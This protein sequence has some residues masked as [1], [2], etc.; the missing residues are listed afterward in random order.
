M[1]RCCKRIGCALLTLLL[2]LSLSGMALA[3]AEPGEYT[4]ATDGGGSRK[5]VY[6]TASLKVSDDGS[7][8]LELLV[9][10]SMSGIKYQGTE[11]EPGE[12]VVKGED[13]YYPY[14]LIL[15]ERTD[16]VTLTA[17]VAAMGRDVELTVGLSGWDTVPGLEAAEEPG[18]AAG[19]EPGVDA[20]SH[21]IA[22]ANA[23]TS[24]YGATTVYPEASLTVAE[25]GS[26]AITVWLKDSIA[27]IRT[28]EGEAVPA[29]EGKTLSMNGE[30]GTYIPYTFAIDMRQAVL[31]LMDDVP[32]MSMVE[33][34]NYGKDMTTTINIDW[35]S[36]TDLEIAALEDGEYTLPVAF[37]TPS[38]MLQLEP[39]AE[40]AVS[41]GKYALSVSFQ[42][43]VISAL[44]YGE[45]VSAAFSNS[46]SLDHFTIE[47]AEEV[48]QIPVKLTVAKMQGTAMAVQSFVIVPD[49]TKAEM[50]QT[51]PSSE[52]EGDAMTFVKADGSGFGMFA[53]QEG[54]TAELKDGMV[55]IHYVP[56]NTTVYNAIHWGTIGD[57]E[58]TKD[59]LF[60]EDGTFD[61][62]LPAAMCGKLIPVAPI[63]VK[64]SATTADQYYLA[65]PAAE[66]L[67][68]EAGSAVAF[69]VKQISAGGE[70]KSVDVYTIDGKNYYKLRD[71]AALLNGTA[72]QFSVDYAP[73]NRIVYV[74]PGEH[75]QPVGG[76][77]EPGQ[78]RSATCVPSGWTLRIGGGNVGIE[79]YNIGGNNYFQLQQ[80]SE[81]LG[82]GVGY[83]M[84]TGTIL[85][86]EN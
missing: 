68:A 38:S 7:M 34:M 44:T 73:E 64:D 14:T 76:E 9:K 40:L 54:T 55:V 74:T 85:I 28:I 53:P 4:L 19:E 81:T 48:G 47:L 86:G 58:L 2:L 26:C 61:I 42:E 37:Q 82:F 67:G 24:S 65:I 21:Q 17:Y 56:K 46:C 72:A 50:V 12:E 18:A 27:N 13:S 52:Y 6:E 16:S 78:D 3:A 69:S 5:P 84:G 10:T 22:V 8:A 41:G 77:L 49:W 36:V 59:L 32:A 57:A 80:L 71:L 1:K 63:K 39:T 66:K 51:Q 70:A 31:T 62:T 33:S 83:D 11:L 15:T 23:S 20:G 75:Y 25:D 30:E 79:A 60:N 43:G 35:T 29:G 45:D